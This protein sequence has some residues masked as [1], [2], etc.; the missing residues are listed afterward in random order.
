MDL[1][2]RKFGVVALIILLV[3]GLLFLIG[4][5][6]NYWID[7]DLTHLGLWKFCGPLGGCTDLTDSPGTWEQSCELTSHQSLYENGS[8]GGSNSHSDASRAGGSTGGGDSSGSEDG[9]DDNDDDH[10]AAA[11]ATDDDD[12]DDV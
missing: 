10:A 5:G 8:G 1:N 11:G 12:N 4:Y 7:T 2:R 3:A 6:T 9:G